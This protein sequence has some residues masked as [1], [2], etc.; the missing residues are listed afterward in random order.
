MSIMIIV[1]I[2]GISARLIC[3]VIISIS[4]RCPITCR[5]TV[6]SVIS[7][8]GKRLIVIKDMDCNNKFRYQ[9]NLGK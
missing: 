5:N 1:V 4:I 2:L 6:V 7:A 8:Q 9:I 3:Y